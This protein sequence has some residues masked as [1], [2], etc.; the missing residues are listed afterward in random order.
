MRIADCFSHG[1]TVSF[2]LHPP[3]TEKVER[4]FRLASLKVAAAGP[5]CR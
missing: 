1:L 3:R 2:E 5:T 4:D